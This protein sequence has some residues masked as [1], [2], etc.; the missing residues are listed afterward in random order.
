MPLDSLA[1]CGIDLNNDEVADINIVLEN[2]AEI[3]G[4]NPSDIWKIN[5]S[6]T[7][8][9]WLIKGPDNNG[10]CADPLDSAAVI[11]NSALMQKTVCLQNI[12]KG[13]HQNCSSFDN[14]G[15]VGFMINSEMGC[16]FGWI[17]LRVFGHDLFIYDYAICN[18]P[19]CYIKAG[20]H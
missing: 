15:F 12:H 8:N 6:G 17:R 5:L 11:D 14:G 2:G 16:Y 20:I 4:H 7:N 10:S 19:Y 1:S 13:F 18:E 9:V 3:L